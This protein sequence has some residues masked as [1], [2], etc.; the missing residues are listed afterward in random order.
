[1]QLLEEIG[2]ELERLE[3]VGYNVAPGELVDEGGNVFLQVRKIH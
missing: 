1:M 2:F 3:R